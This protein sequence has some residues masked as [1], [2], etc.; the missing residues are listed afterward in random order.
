MTSPIPAGPRPPLRDPQTTRSPQ[1]R[2]GSTTYERAIYDDGLVDRLGNLLLLPADINQVIRDRPWPAKRTIYQV[3]SSADP[4][5]RQDGLKKAGLTAIGR[6]AKELIESGDYMPF[7]Q[8][9]GS[10]PPDEHLSVDFVRERTRILARLAWDRLW[11]DL[12]PVA[13]GAPT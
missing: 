1:I 5:E 12:S 4:D 13:L 11:N 8:F 7:C 10:L 3:L 6:K 2:E 9:V